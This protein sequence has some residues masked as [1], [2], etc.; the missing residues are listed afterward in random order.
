MTSKGDLRAAMLQ[1]GRR[2]TEPP[3]PRDS[4]SGRAGKSNVTGYFDPDVKRQLR[5]LAAEHDSTI[6]DLL[7]EALNEL[8]AKHGKPEIAPRRRGKSRP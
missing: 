8:F 4:R 6:Q 1:K 3:P 5:I 2:T 7:G